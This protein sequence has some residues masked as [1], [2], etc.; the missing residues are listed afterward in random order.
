VKWLEEWRALSERIDGLIRATTFFTATLENFGRQDHLGVIGK[1]LLPEFDEVT[2]A[3]RSFRCEHGEEV[4]E[5]GRQALDDYLKENW[6]R[7]LDIGQLQ[8]VA[9]LVV[10]RSRFE[11]AVRETEAAATSLVELA[12]EH[13]RRS[14]LVDEQIRS[15][16]QLAFNDGEPRCEQLGAVH[17]LGHGVWAFKVSGERA[18]T[19]LVLA[20]PLRN[21]RAQVDRA[22]RTVVMT[23]WKLVRE[24]DQ[25]ET[26][27]AEARLQAGAYAAGV[28][29]G[30]ELKRTRYVVLVSKEEI[31]LPD[32][33]NEGAV[34]YR[35]INLAVSPQ[36][37]SV[38]AKKRA[39]RAG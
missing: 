13:L 37:P 20:E 9:P 15:R 12:F 8:V 34:L 7:G 16:W 1:S 35:H 21:L 38:A 32:D 4:S 26:K 19:D 18:I 11:Y 27:A 28:I 14:I 22:A 6:R 30:L 10:C 33:R 5:A 3:L 36:T 25:P 29:G 31:E 2:E 23:E 24:T 17:L 39:V